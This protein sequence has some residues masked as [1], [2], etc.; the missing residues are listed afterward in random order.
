VIYVDPSDTLSLLLSG[1]AARCERRVHRCTTKADALALIRADA[2]HVAIVIRLSSNPDLGL[3]GDDVNEIIRATRQ[4]EHRQTVP[5]VVVLDRH[6]DELSNNVLR[7]G[8]TEVFHLDDQAAIAETLGHFAI[9]ERLPRLQGHVLLV[10]D[11]PAF[12]NHVRDL[13]RSLKLTVDVCASVSDGMLLISRNNYHLAIV[14]ILL[15][16]LHTGI[17]LVRRIR[18]L[19][20]GKAATPILVMSGYRDAARRI[21]AL[22]AGADEFVD[23]PVIDAELIWRIQRLMGDITDS[24][25]PRLVPTDLMKAQSEWQRKG[26][27]SREMEICNALIDGHSDKQIAADLGISFW[28]VRS[29]VSSIFGKLGLLNR[30]ELLTRYLPTR[31]Q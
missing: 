25:L 18:S 24:T 11:S 6:E 20:S 17:E 4:W 19:E 29:H 22:R 31:D 2:T 23:K 1:V 3:P 28:T 14:D 7:S 5:V 27:S 21:E 10:E 26:L 12:A 15:D 13:L 9:S 8:A 30:R 16:G